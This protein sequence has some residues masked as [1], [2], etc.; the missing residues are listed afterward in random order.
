MGDKMRE[1][2]GFTLGVSRLILVV[3]LML[4]C[5]V[6]AQESTRRDGS[7]WLQQTTTDQINC[8]IGFLDGMDLGSYFSYW[9]IS[10]KSPNASAEAV[11]SYN[12]YV[13]KYLNHVSVG[14]IV[15]GMNDFYNDYR[16]RSILI[17]DAAWLVLNNIAGTPKDQIDK[18]TE[19]WRQAASKN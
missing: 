3:I 5:S 17:P 9:G 6:L 2:R 10:K 18:M 14:Q 4:P 13:Q 16:N 19:N 15:D 1:R 8:F 7:W 11:S 12:D